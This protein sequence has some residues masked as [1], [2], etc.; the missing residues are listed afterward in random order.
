MGLLLICLAL[1]T[2]ATCLDVGSSSPHMKGEFKKVGKFIPQEKLIDLDIMLHAEKQ[3]ALHDKFVSGKGFILV[4]LCF[5][6]FFVF[7]KK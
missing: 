5:F 6:S 4:L 1:F 7:S 2:V 3:G